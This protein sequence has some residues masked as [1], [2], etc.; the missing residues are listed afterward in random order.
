LSI[1][2]LEEKI[3]KM[4]QYNGFWNVTGPVP[5]N[6]DAAKKYDHLRKRWVGSMLNVRGVKE[7]KGFELIVLAP[8]SPKQSHLHL[9]IKSFVFMITTVNGW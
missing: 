7:L 5:A 3:R 4:N 6:R 9:A 1:L 8:G 2:T